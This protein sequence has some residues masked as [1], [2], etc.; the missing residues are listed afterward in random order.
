MRV[1]EQFNL[2]GKT[3]LVTGSDTGL[4]QAMAIALAEAGA[5]II[6]TANTGDLSDT[7]KAVV[8]LG[9]QFSGYK[10]DLSNREGLYQFI[11]SV[12]TDHTVDILVNNAGMILRKPVAEHPDDWWDKVIAVNLD[13]QF[14]LAREFGKDMIAKGAGKIIFTCSLLS[15][16]GGITVPG[17]TASKSAVAGLVKAF[18]N[19]W[20]SKGVN[21]N[22]ISPGYIATNNTAALRAD[23]D[24]SKSI[25]DRIPAGRWGDPSDFKGPVVFLASEAGAYVHGTLLTVDGGWMGR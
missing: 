1:L 10:V 13:A 15:F 22:G 16:Q 2:A 21:V 23:P 6:S 3:A 17:Y 7:Q 4:G 9:R 8:G 18:S 19:E 25:L 20:A 14:I 12:K 11:Q 5:D 24:R